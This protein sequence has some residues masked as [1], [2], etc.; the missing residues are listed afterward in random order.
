MVK[1][2]FGDEDNK[3]KYVDV[4]IWSLVKANILSSLV[5]TGIIFVLV[6]ALG[7]IFSF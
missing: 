3:K 4:N 6:Y 1:I 5:I 7:V 2:Y